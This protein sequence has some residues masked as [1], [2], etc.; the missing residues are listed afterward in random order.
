MFFTH[1][2]DAS[3]AGSGEVEVF[4]KG[5]SRKVPCKVVDKGGGFYRATFT[6]K[7]TV[8]HMVFV[9]FAKETVPGG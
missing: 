6:P 9:T 8:P 2:V 7:N 3:Q 4:V 1:L 5:D